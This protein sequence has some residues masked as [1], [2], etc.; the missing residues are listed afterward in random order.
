MSR[1]VAGKKAFQ[2]FVLTVS[3]EISNLK[4]KLSL[5]PFL[6]QALQLYKP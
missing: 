1:N 2:S 6:H 4:A 3:G 5:T